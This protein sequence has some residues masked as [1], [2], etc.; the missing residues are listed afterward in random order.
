VIAFIITSNRANLNLYYR[1]IRGRNLNE[2]EFRE[3]IGYKEEIYYHYCSVNALYGIVTNKSFWLTSLESSND[4]KELKVGEEILTQALNELKLEH[5]DPRYIR[6]FDMIMKANK[7]EKFKKYRPNYKYYGLSFVENKD[8]LTHWE[9]YGDGSRGVCIGVNLWMIKH[10]FENYALPNITTNWLQGAKIIYSNEE[11]VEYAKSSIM[12]KLEGFDMMANLRIEDIKHIFSSI[13]YSALASV[14]PR[15][16]HTGFSDENEY[17]IY[18]EEGEA[19]TISNYF[20]ENSKL[21]DEKIK[22]YL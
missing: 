1:R 18:L 13:Y 20:S 3:L 2:L 14:K 4:L 6:F 19:E 11:Q 16:K 15:F 12:A 22:N 5:S 9:R 7:D 10:F 21:T 8:S 17:R